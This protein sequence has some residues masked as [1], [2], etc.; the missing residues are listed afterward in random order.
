LKGLP[1]NGPES[2][3]SLDGFTRIAA[4]V[5]HALRKYDAHLSTGGRLSTLGRIFQPT[6]DLGYLP[7]LPRTA[8]PDESRAY[9]ARVA[10]ELEAHRARQRQNP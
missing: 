2:P 1:S 5:D 3:G 9:I 4:T 8:D 6:D 10:R 7:D